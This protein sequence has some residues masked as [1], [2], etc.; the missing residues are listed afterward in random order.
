MTYK[1]EAIGFDGS[2]NWLERGADLDGSADSK[3]GLFSAWVRLDDGDGVRQFLYSNASSFFFAEREAAGTFVIRGLNVGGSTVLALRTTE[4]YLA[5]AAWIHL[6]ASW[7]LATG[8]AEFYVNDED[9]TLASVLTDDE[10]DWSRPNWRVGVTSGESLGLQGRAA[11]FF[12]ANERRDLS[13]EANRRKF[14]NADGNPVPLGTNGELPTGT[15]PIIYMKNGNP[16]EGVNAGTGGDFTKNGS[17][18]FVHGPI[19]RWVGLH[20]TTGEVA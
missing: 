13:V 10:V 20:G 14:I 3:V 19:I 2:T 8:A 9:K 16:N 1:P 11:D 7:D 5:S 18:S 6:L 4:T 17:F 15:A 12:L